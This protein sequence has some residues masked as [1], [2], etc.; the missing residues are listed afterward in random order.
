MTASLLISDEVTPVRRGMRE[1]NMPSHLDN[2][3]FK[4]S[5]RSALKPRGDE[6]ESVMAAELQQLLDIKVW[7]GIHASDL[8]QHEKVT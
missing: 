2:Y 4:I 3:A 8:T 7:H 1:R 6:A 5:V